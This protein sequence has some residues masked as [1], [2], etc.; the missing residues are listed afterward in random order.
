VIV[1]PWAGLGLIGFMINREPTHGLVVLQYGGRNKC[2][3]KSHT[4]V[5]YAQ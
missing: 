3:T 5:R 2:S 4:K 1:S